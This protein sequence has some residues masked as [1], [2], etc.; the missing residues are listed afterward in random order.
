ML[1]CAKS[2]FI[3]TQG[4]SSINNKIHMYIDR[5]PGIS[6]CCSST[7]VRDSTS[8]DRRV[9]ELLG[10]WKWAISNKYPDGTNALYSVKSSDVSC[11]RARS[12]L[13][14]GP[15]NTVQIIT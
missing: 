12:T 4:R 14:I 10:D 9:R 2:L 11:P 15:L 5:C 1:K 8:R 7:V 13:M 6:I 3:I